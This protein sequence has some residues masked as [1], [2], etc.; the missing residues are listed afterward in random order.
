MGWK[1]AAGIC[2]I[3]API[4][5]FAGIFSAIASD[6][7]FS[8]AGNALSDLGV[9][10]GITSALFNYG[11]IAAGTLTLIFSA[12][13][14]LLLPGKLGKT[15]AILFALVAIDLAAIGVFTEKFEPTHYQ[16]SLVFF[17]LFP[18]S[19]F[20]A[21]ASLYRSS[22]KKLAAI[23][24]LLSLAAVAAWAIQESIGFGKNVAIPETIAALSVGIW[25]AMMGW[26]MLEK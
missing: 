12:R 17:T 5:A 24:L 4:A 16:V 13:L 22:R 9:A 26:K 10:P 15:A 2:G 1:K 8:W 23:T 20:F 7:Q 6:P 18:I 25:S 11:L 21:A 14:P 19:L 3:L